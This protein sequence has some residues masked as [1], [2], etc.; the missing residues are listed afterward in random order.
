[1]IHPLRK[2]F[3]FV[4]RLQVSRRATLLVSILSVLLSLGIGALLLAFLG[5]APGAA[6]YSIFSASLFGGPFALSDTLV[7]ATPLILC[8]LGCAVAFRARLWNVGAE[9]QLLVGAW[10]ATGIASGDYASH[11][12]APLL[13]LSMA[14]TASLAGGIWGGLVGL[15]K[16]RLGVN[17]IIT[18]LMLVYVAQKLINFFVFGPWSEGG[19]PLTPLFPQAAW[20]P[21]LSDLATYYPSCA[22]LTAH[23]GI[24]L[25]LACCGVLSVFFKRSVW[26]FKLRLL[27]D[28]PAAA[29][30]A[31]LNVERHIFWTLL[32]SG[33]LAG[34][35]GMIEVAGVV[36]RLQDRFS[37]GYGFVAIA[38]AWL[39]RLD[40]W[41]L[42]VSAV[43]F[44][45][46]MVG[47][48]EVQP[49]GIALML[50]GAIMIVVVASE[51]LLRLQLR[52][53]PQAT[54][55]TTS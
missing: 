53:R 20:L 2:Q 47:A 10:A 42:L 36:H 7:K 28:S 52:R 12:P 18:S 50:Q 19:F 26:G 33:A 15:L 38:V 3:Y 34:L 24:L 51:V 5:V 21:R 8:G 55:E 30:Y 37:P 44:A 25:A 4:P 35:A 1:V 14:L 43:L 16:S 23:L 48:K 29:R 39:G 41:G 22:G 17:E 11:L 49:Y 54:P 27:G 46:L 45:A 9:G 13:W 32:L 31:G 40:P 6:Y